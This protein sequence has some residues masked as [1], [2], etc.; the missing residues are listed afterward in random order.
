MISPAPQRVHVFAL[1]KPRASGPRRY[2]VKWRI[3]GRDRTRSFKTR[4]EADRFRSRLLDAVHQG[5]P[6]DPMEGVPTSWLARE[7]EA[8]TWWTWSREWCHLKWPQWSGHSRRS[9]VE[10]LALLTPHLVRLGA[11]MA[12]DGLRPWLRAEGFTVDKEPTGPMAEWLARWSAP[13]AEIDAPML[14]RVL[15]RALLRQDSKPMA[16]TV[17]RRH[18]NQLA[19]V[20]Q[21]AVRRGLLPF[22]PMERVE[23]RNPAHSLELDVSTVP[24]PADVEAIVE[25]TWAQPPNRAQCAVLFATIGLA[26]LRP[27]EAAA[28][29]V[30][31]V[32]LPD[33]GWG[34]AFVRS[35]ITSPGP[36]F[37]ADGT[38]LET[39]GLKHRAVNAVREVPLAPRLVEL[40]RA[41]LVRFPP[42]EGRVFSN[43]AGRPIAS[44]NYGPVWI[45]ARQALWPE[46]HHLAATTA[47]DLRHSA[48]T[49]MLRAGVP[50]AEV[51]RRLGHSV[52]VLLRVYAGVY[53][54][55]RERSNALIEAALAGI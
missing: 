39:K 36:R 27:S 3:D 45:R 11:P 18:R 23:W 2:Y 7:G 25:W 14:E 55:E 9:A 52:D 4:V 40:L 51:A 22:S 43:G 8:P 24:S 31:D 12:P 42:I 26:G 20:L 35:A 48:A 41:H 10:T 29:R 33:E 15:H 50:A 19:S 1:G 16:A 38:A 47:Y 17:A 28:V 13:L 34:V 54:G 30:A 21:S 6:F 53:D 44:S 37:T 32:S 49:M 46:P 5:A